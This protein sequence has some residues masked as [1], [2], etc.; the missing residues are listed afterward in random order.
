VLGAIMAFGP[1]LALVLGALHGGR[2]TSVLVLG[3]VIVAAIVTHRRTTPPRR[4]LE[5]VIGEDDAP[6]APEPDV[7]LFMPSPA[8]TFVVDLE[9][10]AVCKANDAASA[11]YGWSVKELGTMTFGDLRCEG[12]G[13]ASALAPPSVA[14]AEVF[15]ETTPWQG[16]CR[17]RHRT[18]ETIDVLVLTRPIRFRGRAASLCVVQDITT[19][20]AREEQRRQVEKME[21]VGRLA[22]GV[23]HDFNNMLSIIFGFSTMLLEETSPGDASHEPLEEI[24]RAAQRSAE[25]SKQLLAFS[26]QTP[27]T[28]LANIPALDVARAIEAQRASMEALLGPAI[29]LTMEAP[30]A[31][32]NA[33]VDRAQ[34]E[35]IIEKLTVNAR[36]AMPRGGKLAIRVSRAESSGKQGVVLLRVSDTGRGM[37]ASTRAHVFEPFFTTKEEGK[38]TGLGLAIVFALVQ[39]HGGQVSVQSELGH[40]TTFEIRFPECEV[41]RTS[42]VDTP[43]VVSSSAAT[44]LLVED[45]D[46]LRRI[47]GRALRRTGFNVLSARSAEEALEI[48]SKHTEVIALLITD[49]AM[50]KLSGPELANELVRERPD[51]KILYV[52]GK[53]ADELAEACAGRAGATFLQ[54][55]ITPIALS[56]TVRSILEGRAPALTDSVSHAAE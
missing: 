4:R 37:D 39:R 20:R 15:S 38:G 1:S 40:G 42:A 16:L 26:R 30:P 18:G 7:D 54:K 23:A 17:H 33:K 28:T 34:L 2:T 44:V 36:D 55:P 51:L 35:E 12:S 10:R 56:N 46:A 22:G 29:E 50:P 53:N 5:L 49:I 41:E 14:G 25:L 32:L 21:A 47:M 31:P 19:L 24:Q 48:A 11:L 13:P 27:T 52:S 9:T 6:A 3:L 43:R 8:P 45:E